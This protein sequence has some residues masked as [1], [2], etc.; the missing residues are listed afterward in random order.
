MHFSS[1]SP[2]L[3]HLMHFNAHLQCKWVSNNSCLSAEQNPKVS[4]TKSFSRCNR[5][6][7][8]L[9]ASASAETPVP[10]L[11][12]RAGWDTGPQAQCSGKGGKLVTGSLFSQIKFPA[13]AQLPGKREFCSPFSERNEMCC[14][15]SHHRSTRTIYSAQLRAC[16]HLSCAGTRDLSKSMFLPSPHGPSPLPHSLAQAASSQVLPTAF[17]LVSFGPSLILFHDGWGK[18]VMACISLTATYNHSFATGASTD[19]FSTTS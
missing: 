17:Q 12:G 14:L 16:W 13:C 7:A 2:S 1:T 18:Q 4:T 3:T 5:W 10:E 8:A 9:P 15:S 11:W 19:R 6:S